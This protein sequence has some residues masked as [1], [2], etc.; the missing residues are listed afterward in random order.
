MVWLY[1]MPRDELANFCKRLGYRFTQLNLLEVA[2]THRSY[3]SENNERREFLGDSVVNFIIGEALFRRYPKHREG[4]LTRLRATLIRGET[5]TEVAKELQVGDYLTLGDGETKMGGRQRS[6]ILAD[7]LEAVIA[8]VYLDADMDTCRELVLQWFGERLSAVSVGRYA[9]DAKTQL[10]E[11]L[12]ANQYTLPDYQIDHV[13][14]DMHKQI[15]YINCG[16]AGLDI[17]T[18]GKGTSRRRAEQAA[19]EQFLNQLKVN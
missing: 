6:S 7:A 3:A 8:A 10:Q 2:L 4:E 9:K 5:L 13:E 18:Q 17:N 14:G 1:R 11:Y 15:F 19:A 16:V 12:Q